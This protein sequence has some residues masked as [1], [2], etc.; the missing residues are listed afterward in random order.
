[1]GA[2]IRIKPE[3]AEATAARFTAGSF[4]PIHVEYRPDGNTSFWFDR[5][6][7]KKPAFIEIVRA[8]PLEWWAIIGV[9]G[10]A[11]FTDQD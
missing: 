5:A 7:A 10:G 2:R 8:L 4:H 9:V 11:P 6:T 1:M 3:H